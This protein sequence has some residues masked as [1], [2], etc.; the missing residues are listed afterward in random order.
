MPFVQRKKPTQFTQQS[1]DFYHTME[2]RNFS[3]LVRQ[4]DPLCYYCQMRGI[5]RA[6]TLADHVKPRRLFPALQ[7]VRS[8]VKPCCDPCHNLKRS[9]E[10]TI[11]TQEQFEKEFPV[12]IQLITKKK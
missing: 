5:I 3:I 8:N 6:A 2:W 9:W 1:S 10:R 7:L 4:E 11:A 12:F